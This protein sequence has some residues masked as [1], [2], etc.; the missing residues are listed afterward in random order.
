MR[1][2]R[3]LYLSASLYTFLKCT[4]GFARD[5]HSKSCIF[6]HFRTALSDTPNI[7]PIDTIELVSINFF[8]FSL[9]GRSV[10]LLAIP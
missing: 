8:N 3:G 2:L 10:F 7:F 5:C 1:L 6:A 4:S 9:V